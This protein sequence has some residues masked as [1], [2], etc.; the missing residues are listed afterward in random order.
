MLKKVMTFMILLAVGMT[1]PAGTPPQPQETLR[2]VDASG[3]AD[4]IC[5]G[6]VTSY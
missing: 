6:E 5:A 4:N 2:K 1:V 3:L